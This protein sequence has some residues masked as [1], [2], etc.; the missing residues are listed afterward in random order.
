MKLLPEEV[1]NG[2]HS[3]PILDLVDPLK[4]HDGVGIVV[5]DDWARGIAAEQAL[6]VVATLGKRYWLVVEQ[7]WPVARCG[8]FD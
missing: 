5:L 4:Q 7:S 2:L 8:S 1:P 6:L 3:V